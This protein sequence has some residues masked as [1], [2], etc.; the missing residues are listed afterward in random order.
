MFGRQKQACR[1]YEENG[2]LVV[3]TPYIPELVQAIKGLPHTERRYDPSRKVWLV[4][5]NN[6]QQ[7][8]NLIKLYAGEEV[9]LPLCPGTST[10]GSPFPGSG[11]QSK[12]KVTKILQMLYI[13][14]CK[15]REDGSV[16]AYGLIGAEWSAIFPEKTLRAWFEGLDP[17]EYQKGLPPKQ[18]TETLYT[19]L[20]IK[21]TATPEEIKSAFRRMAIHT[22]PDHNHEPDA[23]EMF[24]KVKQAY[25]ALSD[26]NKRAR[27]DVGLQ[28]QTQ[29]ERQERTKELRD[30][31]KLVDPQSGYRAPL[32]CGLVMVDGVESLG[33]I[34]VTKIYA[35]E[36]IVVNGKTLVTS[37]PMGAKQPKEEWI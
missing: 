23:A 7:V 29:V 26:P 2:A 20:A 12:P 14:A 21:P 27:Y 33:R 13:G 19:I 5:A 25:D 6:G 37:W 31:H 10:G 1:I 16:S 34:E 32:R 28:L 24:I 35:W 36:D 17:E 30:W 4:S 11:V 22:H 15:E 8:A 18:K 9:P 3:S